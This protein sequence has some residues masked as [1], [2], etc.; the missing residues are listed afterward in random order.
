MVLPS[1]GQCWRRRC[2]LFNWIPN[3][4]SCGWP[5]QSQRCLR[6]LQGLQQSQPLL[7]LQSRRHCHHLSLRQVRGL[8]VI[9]VSRWGRRT[10]RLSEIDAKIH[11][12]F[13]VWQPFRWLWRCF[14][15]RI[16]I[17]IANQSFWKSLYYLLLYSDVQDEQWHQVEF[18][19]GLHPWQ[20]ATH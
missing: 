10:N 18:K 9:P 14:A 2:L 4:L 3:G 16:A 20:Y 8:G 19:M 13:Q 1:L 17:G 15:I 7:H 11:W 12:P 5:R 6:D